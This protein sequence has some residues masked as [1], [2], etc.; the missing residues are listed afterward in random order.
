[1]NTI[2]IN[3]TF[4]KNNLFK[5][6]F[7]C[8]R[9]PLQKYK[10][11]YA[12]VINTDPASKPGTHWV[13]LY[14]DKDNHAEFFDSFGRP[15]LNKYII[16]FIDDFCASACWNTECIQSELSI[17]C[18]QFA[19][20]FIKARLRGLTA[21]KFLGLFTKDKDR[22]LENDAII[23][24]FNR[25]CKAYQASIRARSNKHCSKLRSRMRR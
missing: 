10:L 23:E 25:Q 24:K 8:D 7:P 3:K 12:L 13:A 21:D 19:L 15:L 2:Q 6:V 17:K 5:G 14:I 22:L 11:P 4:F 9:I 18:G 16:E 1:M 20:G